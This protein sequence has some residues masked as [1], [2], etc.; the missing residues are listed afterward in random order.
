MTNR[1][2]SNSGFRFSPAMGDFVRWPRSHPS[3]VNWVMFIQKLLF[4]KLLM[5]YFFISRT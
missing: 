1:Y 2:H 4:L 5:S 3:L